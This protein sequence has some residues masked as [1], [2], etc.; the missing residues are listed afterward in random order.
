MLTTFEANATVVHH[1]TSRDIAAGAAGPSALASCSKRAGDHA[2]GGAI[3]ALTACKVEP[4]FVA[5]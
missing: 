2:A 4:S 1:A 3:D 5:D